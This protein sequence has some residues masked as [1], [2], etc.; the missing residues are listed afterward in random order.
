MAYFDLQKPPVQRRMRA[1]VADDSSDWRDLV[2]VLLRVEDYL[3]VVARVEDGQQALEAVTVLHPELLMMDLGIGSIDALTT[4][5]L[6]LHR[7]PSLVVILVADRD[8][9]R[10]R[11]ICQNSGAKY[12]AHKGRLLEELPQILIEI[13]NSLGDLPRKVSTARTV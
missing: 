4:T 13:K 3:E 8:T 7:F 1:V 6:L 5:S 10:L 9:P 11:T 2:S 12:F